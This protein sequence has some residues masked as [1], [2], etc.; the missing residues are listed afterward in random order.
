MMFLQWNDNLIVLYQKEKKEEFY[1]EK[2][3]TDLYICKWL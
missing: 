1:K 3:N 2:E